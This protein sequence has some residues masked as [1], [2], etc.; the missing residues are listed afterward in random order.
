[1]SIGYRQENLLG[2]SPAIRRKPNWNPNRDQVVRDYK[3]D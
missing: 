3:W 1:M 2:A